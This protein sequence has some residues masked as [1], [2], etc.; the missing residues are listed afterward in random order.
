[1]DNVE[2]PSKVSPKAG[3]FRCLV[4]LPTLLCL[5]LSFSSVVFCFLVSFKTSQLEE[6]VKVLEQTRA[7]TLK[8]NILAQ[9]V[10]LLP[11][12]RDLIED[13]LEK[14]LSKEMPK[15]RTVRDAPLECSCPP[16]M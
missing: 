14:R 9:D 6:R 12:L 15:Q 2:K 5:S 8:D 10:T 4:A 11:A 16:G 13:V 1:M 3:I 7:P